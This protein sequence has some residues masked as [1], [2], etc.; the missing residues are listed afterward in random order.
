MQALLPD[1]DPGP[2]PPSESASR[3]ISARVT[4]SL[5]LLVQIAGLLAGAWTLFVTTL[6]Q[7]LH[8]FTLAGL[9]GHALRYALL[10]WLWSAAITFLLHFTLPAEERRDVAWNTLRTSSAAVWFAPAILL[11]SEMS[12]AALAAG[13]VL[14]VKAT[15]L[16][17]SQWRVMHP[18]PPPLPLAPAV[19]GLFGGHD[20]PPRAFGRELAP[21]LAS[22]CLAQLGAVELGMRRPLAA[23]AL[24]VAGSS[25]LTIQA[26][27]RGAWSE[28]RPSSLPRSFLGAFLT[29]LLAAGLT[30]TGL[31]GRVVPGGMGGGNSAT[32]IRELLRQFMGRDQPSDGPDDA[33]SDTK[34]KGAGNA[35][36]QPPEPVPAAGATV[37]GG[38]FPGVILRPEVQPAVTLIA[39]LAAVKSGF[40]SATPA[41]PFS[42][43]FGGEYWMYRWLTYN[44]RPPPN[45]HF[46]RGSPADLTFRTV[47]HWPLQM[48]ARQKLIQPIDLACCALVQVEIRNADSAAAGVTMELVAIGERG[49]QSLGM[50]HVSSLPDLTKDPVTPV[51]ETLDFAVPARLPIGLVEEF[52][53]VFRRTRP[54]NDRSAR[55]A[56]ARFLLAPR[57]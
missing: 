45:S 49:E 31:G 10:T 11:L 14:V 30:V 40:P 26:M 15:R 34:A 12:P 53:V 9:A 36:V 51:P 47:D 28:E 4:G 13:L 54:H 23:S 1:L 8:R 46:E 38:S 20:L 50:A 43:P 56:I 52:K 33:I 57:F 48:E 32:G 2:L 41:R 6:A 19:E 35:D 21:A 29:I 39:P 27:S 22:A 7:H 37:P 17:Y 3:P 25:L 18:Q 42:I 24:L 5:A 55:I 44:N 16:L